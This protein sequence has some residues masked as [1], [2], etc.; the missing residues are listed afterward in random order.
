[1]NE[2]DAPIANAVVMFSRWSADRTQSAALRKVP[3]PTDG[4]GRFEFMATEAEWLVAASAPRSDGT[5]APVTEVVAK[6]GTTE[7]KI[8]VVTRAARAAKVTCEVVDAKSGGALPLASA[9]LEPA[10]GFRGNWNLTQE[11]SLGSVVVSGLFAGR[12]RIDLETIDHRRASREFDVASDH[13]DVRLRVEVGALARVRGRIEADAARVTASSRPVRIYWNPD[14]ARLVDESGRI[15]SEK[16]G[17]E[18]PVPADGRFFLDGFVPG[19]A[20]RIFL[21]DFDTVFDEVVFTAQRDE[22][23]DVVLHWTPAAHL[24]LRS[25]ADTSKGALT[26]DLQRD[27]EPWHR[28][29][30]RIRNSIDDARDPPHTL[31]PGHYRWQ[32]FLDV[33]SDADEPP[34]VTTASGEFDV[35]AGATHVLRIDELR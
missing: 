27:D 9:W 26:V 2:D 7:L 25:R 15:L 29:F 31:R 21:T 12:W 34:L 33:E 16:R 19:K 11:K 30:W 8:R 32:A 13:D 23:R 28:E 5:A 4:D 6:G 17:A 20:A 22:V 18:A 14:D 1:V 3:R 24:S 35:A 10:E